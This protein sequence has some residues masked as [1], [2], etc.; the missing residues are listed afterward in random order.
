MRHRLLTTISLALI[1]V[2]LTGSAAL[3]YLY[4][5]QVA[6]TEGD[7]T[8]Y[9]M[10]PVMWDQ[11]NDWLAD[12]GFMESDA[13]DTRVETLSGTDKPWMVAEDRTLTSIPVDMDSQ[14]NIYFVTGETDAT[15]MDIITGYD[16]EITVPDAADLE[17]GDSFEI[18][19]SGWI[20]TDAGVD[21]N[22]VYKELAFQT[23][24]SA[25]EEI[26]SNI[27]SSASAWVHPTGFVDPDTAWTDN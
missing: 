12:N 25:N 15:S 14:N 24:I 2:I 27:Y 26:T 18:E 9:T 19:Q 11:N 20:D 6:I 8:D 16:G 7:S 13:L 21:K 17:L 3:A 22:L 5:V 23:Y 4:R 10:L 1:L